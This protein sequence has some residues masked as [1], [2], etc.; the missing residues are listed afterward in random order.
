MPF[1][2]SRWVTFFT[3]FL[4]NKMFSR[5]PDLHSMVSLQRTLGTCEY[6]EARAWLAWIHG[7]DYF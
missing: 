5:G 2:A 4:P 6:A 3:A 7:L 1:R